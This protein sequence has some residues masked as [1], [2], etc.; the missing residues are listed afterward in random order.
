MSTGTNNISST[1]GSRQG[2]NSDSNQTNS[3][4][5]RIT[6]FRPADAGAQT[7]D[8]W[9]LFEERVR[10]GP[11]GL[12]GFPGQSLSPLRIVLLDG[13][14]AAG[15]NPLP[16]Q[17]V[18]EF[19]PRRRGQWHIPPEEEPSLTPEQ[20]RKALQQLKKHVYNPARNKPRRW[21][22][23]NRENASNSSHLKE[24]E[25]DEDGKGC[26]ICLEDFV[27]NEEVQMTPCK[28]MFHFKCILPWVKSHGQ[29]PVCRFALCDMDR[30]ALSPNN[31]PGLRNDIMPGDLI[32]LVRA[33]EE[34]FEWLTVPR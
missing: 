7:T 2:Q 6:S 22:F 25:R 27:P 11:Y 32:S 3:P 9:Q 33:V 31:L 19:P 24:E 21:T 28:H 10:W 4:V 12:T 13:E 20:Q 26:P 34:T 14:I 29:C 8:P 1:A 18:R 5:P 17:F 15:V 16:R 23:Y 30:R